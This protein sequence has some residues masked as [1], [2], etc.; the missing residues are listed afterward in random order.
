MLLR[1]KVFP[2]RLCTQAALAGSWQVVGINNQIKTK[3]KYCFLVDK[4]KDL[5]NKF[6][7]TMK[8]FDTTRKTIMMNPLYR[9]WGLREL[10]E[11]L[12]KNFLFQCSDRMKDVW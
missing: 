7:T 1:G 6:E 3:A 4:V 10:S 8:E 9:G 11:K 2:P 5:I 12:M